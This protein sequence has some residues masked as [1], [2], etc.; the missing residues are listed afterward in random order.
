M[1][2]AIATA[3]A[4]A[5]AEPKAEPKTFSLLGYYQAWTDGLVNDL[6]LTP[7]EREEAMAYGE[8]MSGS[9]EELVEDGSFSFDPREAQAVMRLG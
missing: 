7:E 3:T 4:L 8:M 5:A 9:I 1:M 6:S 2:T